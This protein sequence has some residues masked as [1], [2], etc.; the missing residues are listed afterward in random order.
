MHKLTGLFVLLAACGVESE[1]EALR[2]DAPER[3]EFLRTLPRSGGC[4]DATVFGANLTDTQ[5]VFFQFSGIAQ[6]ANAAG[7][8][9]TLQLQLPNPN[10]SVSYRTGRRLTSATC[11]G[12]FPIPGPSV[13]QDFNAVGGTVNV[14]ARPTGNMGGDPTAELDVQ[15]VNPSFAGAGMGFGFMGT[16]EIPNISVGLYPP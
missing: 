4:G 13:R 11:V 15:L 14:I 3:E 16:I 9:I 12:A 6:A 1:E 10:V 8:P 7:Q 2:F 5:A